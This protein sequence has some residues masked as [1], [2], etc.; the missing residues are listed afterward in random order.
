RAAVVAQVDR[1]GVAV[2]D[3]ERAGRRA[4]DR[5]TADGEGPAERGV[6][7]RVHLQLVAGVHLQLDEVPGVGRAGVDIERGAGVVA[8]RH[9]HGLAAER[10]AGRGDVDRAAGRQRVAGDVHHVAGELRAREVREVG[11]CAARTVRLDVED[12]PG[13][14]LRADVH[15]TDR[16]AGDRVRGTR[17]ESA[18]RD[19]DRLARSQALGADAEGRTRG[20]LVGGE[21]DERPGEVPGARERVRPRVGVRRAAVE[22]AAARV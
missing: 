8:E 18:E 1:R 21:G 20:G 22:E 5:R 4:G 17:V 12:V 3:R 15:R 9:V 13:E 19:V 2:V 16:V 11:R 10:A 7:G 14:G 6:P